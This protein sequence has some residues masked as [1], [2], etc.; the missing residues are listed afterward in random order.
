M[1]SEWEIERYS[2]KLWE[3]EEVRETD[4]DTYTHTKREREREREREAQ[5]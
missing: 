3:I 2:R 1:Q 4:T 5:N